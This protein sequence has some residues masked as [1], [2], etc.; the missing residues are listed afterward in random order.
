MRKF[1]FGVICFLLLYSAV[2]AKDRIIV[3]N[4][5]LDLRN[6]NW[7]KDGIADLTGNWEFYWRKFYPPQLFED[8]LTAHTKQYAFVPSFWNNYIP[9]DQN[10]PNGFGY[11]TYHLTVL[12][13]SSNEQLAL[14][15]L[16]V[17]SS[18]RLFVNGKEL[19]KV[20]LP[21]TTEESTIADLKPSI[22]NVV[23]ENNKLDIVMQ[24]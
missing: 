13:P 3:Q 6:W 21:D 17:E 7:Q 16:T 4:G 22:V 5:L 14:K 9:P 20:G 2:S 23:P 1:C 12:C 10:L 15:F 11:A 8:T 24:V 19:L 18:Y